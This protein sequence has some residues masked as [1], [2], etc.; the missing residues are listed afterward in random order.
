MYA[1][2]RRSNFDCDEVDQVVVFDIHDI[3]KGY[4]ESQYT[5]YILHEK[6]NGVTNLDDQFCTCD[7]DFAQITWKH[8]LSWTDNKEYHSITWYVLKAEEVH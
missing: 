6:N 3:A 1:V 8:D 5:A 2:V 7:E 4:M